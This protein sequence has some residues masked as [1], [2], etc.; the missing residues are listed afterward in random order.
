MLIFGKSK[1]MK[2]HLSF[3]YWLIFSCIFCFAQ[4]I[5]AQDY[6]LAYQHITTENGLSNNFVT[7]IIQDKK[8]FIWLGTQEGLNKYDGYSFKIYK[9]DSEKKYYLNSNHI[10]F[11]AEGISDNSIWIGTTTG[12]SK[13]HIHSDTIENISF[14]DK[15]RINYISIDNQKIVWVATDKGLFKKENE[16][17]ID[18]SLTSNLNQNYSFIDEKYINGTKKQVLVITELINPDKHTLFWRE[19]DNESWQKIVTTRYNLQYIEKNGTIWTSYKKEQVKNGDTQ[20]N[21]KNIKIDSIYFDKSKL[22]RMTT[23]F[24]AFQDKIENNKANN[25][26]FFDSRGIALV[27]LTTKKFRHWYYWKYFAESVD[28]YTVEMIFRDTSKNY[29]ICTQGMGVFLFSD[30]TLSNFRTYKYRK[31]FENSLSNPSTRAIYQDSKTKTTWIGTYNHKHN[32]DIFLGDSL[33]KTLHINDY[34]HLIKEDPYHT[35]ILWFATSAGI[36]KIDKNKFE[37]LETYEMDKNLL[38]DILPLN[39]TTLWI[40][41]NDNLHHFN[42]TTKKFISYSH[43]NKITYLHNDKKNDIW[44]GSKDKGIGFLANTEKFNSQT[45]HNTEII[46]YNPNKN[47]KNQTCYVKN[48]LESSTE[49]AIFWIATTTGLYKFDSKKRQFLE[50]YT[51]KEGLPNNVIYAILEDDEGNLWGSTNH[52]IFK[53]NPKTKNFTN[54]DKQDGL[55]ENEFNTFSYFK[56]KDGELFFGGINGVNAFFPKNMKKNEFVPPL[57]LTCFEKLGKKVDFEKPI[58]E[59]KQISLNKEDAQMLTFRF[60]ALNFYQSSKNKY[61]YK[62][63]P[64]QKEWIQLGVKNELTLSNLAAGNY[65]L[66]IKGSN[67]HGVWNKKG[68][69]INIKIIPPFW[70]TLWFKTLVLFAFLAGSYFYYHYKVRET[71]Q[72]AIFLEN[73]VEERTHE[74][75]VQT[76]ELQITNEKLKELDDFKE[77]T[78]NML[79]HDLKNPLGTIIFE[80]K[81]NIPIRKASQRMMNLLMALL[82]SQ[83]IQSPQFELNLKR[84]NFDAILNNVIEEIE[85][86]LIEKEIQII[87][88][89]KHF[90]YLEI[91]K[92]LIQRV[93]VNLLT[94]AI[95]YSS[96][97]SYIK[98]SVQENN[99]HFAQITVTDTG[100]G[101]PKNQLDSIFDSYKQVNAQKVGNI[102]ST[103]LGLSF[104]K[105]AVEAH[106]EQS[107]IWV[108]SIP[109]QETNFH[110]IVPLLEIKQHTEQTMN[111]KTQNIIPTYQF[112]ETELNYLLPFIRELK[113][114]EV[115]QATQIRSILNSLDDESTIIT[116]WKNEIQEII[117][118]VDEEKYQKLLII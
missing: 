7:T 64:I 68:I 33:K 34:T 14:F 52:G 42:P 85:V 40:A 110:F 46:Y 4:K 10:T 90:F 11:L 9:S 94:N 51:E 104:C 16:K 84:T 116:E 53:F 72:R 6:D 92:D 62:L 12:L 63:E 86:F 66:H 65:T 97:R 37:V 113:E 58:S 105:L 74:I 32:I 2:R 107:K 50:H 54:F 67:N 91:D 109:N 81:N 43:L 27:D 31:G 80:A 49:L 39:D 111:N 3:I 15:K 28:Q 26:W 44:I 99:S 82:D 22:I 45:A 36:R 73:Q 13:L 70:Q 60:A 103:G 98:I 56:S 93:L 55:Q 21:K 108:D 1:I 83:K 38:H 112:S 8:G 117:Y 95:K 59:I 57:Y 89:E 106:S 75:L 118:R 115:Y 71:K 18:I 48:I 35:N 96:K 29:W 69:K 61:A 25:I 19:K 102:A 114:L 87:Y 101:I 20:V 5:Q 88:E 100:K 24:L 47:L 76:E 79:V 17:W 78:T 77:K 23:P 30:Y 41:G